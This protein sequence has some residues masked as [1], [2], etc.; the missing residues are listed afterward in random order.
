[1]TEM[2]ET[3]INDTWRLLLP[4]HRACRDE[5]WGSQWPTWEALRLKS[6]SRNLHPG[7]LVFDIGAEEGDMPALWS[8]WGCDVVL[9]EPNPKVW[10]NIRAIWEANGLPDPTGW[11]VG[12]AG[13]KVDDNRPDWN[14]PPVGADGSGWPTCAYGPVIGD[15][16]FLC[17]LERPDVP[18]ITIDALA[19]LHGPPDV[20]TIDVEG[21]EMSVLEGAEQTLTHAKPL[22]YL[23]VHPQFMFDA[24]GVTIAEFCAWLT[25]RGYQREHLSAGHEWHELW[26]PEEAADRVILPY[27]GRQ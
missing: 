8:S 23:S 18:V 20:I 21:A 2:R 17:L 13:A 24:W 12:F 15:H 26:W 25:E 22:L 1:M 19:G 9:V 6:M 7:D 14:H 4:E 16:G 3:L 5:P 27:G 10:P 11:W